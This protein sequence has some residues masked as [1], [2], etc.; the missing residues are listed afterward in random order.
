MPGRFLATLLT[1][2]ASLPAQDDK[3]APDASAQDAG[4]QVTAFLS[5]YCVRCHG[6]DRQKGELRLDTLSR[7]FEDLPTAEQWRAVFYRVRFDEMPP[8][9][10]KKQPKGDA[11]RALLE[12]IDRGLQAQGRGIHLAEKMRLPQYGNYVDH[13]MLFSGEVKELPYTEARLWRQRP[14]IYAQLWARHYGRQHRYSVKI[15]GAFRNGDLHQIQHGP[16]RGKPITARYFADERYANPFYEYVHHASGITDYADIAADQSSLEALLT[17]AEKMAEILT[18]GQPVAITTE[19]KT[20][21][22]RH[23]NNHGMFVG[24]EVSTSTELRGRIPRVFRAVMEHRAAVPR[25]VFANALQLGFQLF[26]RRVPSVEEV[27]HYFEDLFLKNASLGHTMALQ[28][29]LVAIAISPEFVYRMEM[30]L[31]DVDEH[32]RRL[33]SPLELVFALQYSLTDASPFG[34]DAFEADDVFQKQVEPLIQR[35]LTKDHRVAYPGHGWL[36]QQMQKGKLQTRA[37]VEAAVRHLLAAKPRNLTPNHNRDIQSVSNPRILQFFREFFGYH[38]AED[39]FKE[40]DNFKQREGFQ[41]FG[42]HTATRL[43]YDTDAL[44]LHVLREDRDVLYELL[45]TNKVFVSYWSGKHDK[46]QIRRAGGE[47]KYRLAH[48][49]QSYNLDPMTFD[50]QRGAPIEVPLDQRCGV[51]TQPSW[52]VAHSGNFD[53]DPVRRGKW[54][55]EKLLAGYV[56]DVPITVQAVIPDSETMTLRQRFEVVHDSECWQCH[57]KM[58]PLGMPFEAFNHVG[59][60]RDLER[61]KPVDTRGSVDYTDGYGLDGNAGDGNAGEGGLDGGVANVRE[62]MERLARSPLVRQSF[63]RHVFRFWMGRNE[64]LRDSQTLLA[65]DKAYVESGGSFRELLVSLLTSDS[66]LYRK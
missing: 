26:L 1:T 28:A 9:T 22:S 21:D 60:F 31:G 12:W 19:V 30:G 47:Q 14:G 8:R 39:V 59:R 42:N 29:V 13:K 23:G 63:I 4:K 10:T 40:V 44:V 5:N 48:D 33:L 66:F 11:R 37:D 16:H 3:P 18:V 64:A 65:M 35:A 50:H 52:L 27:E 49:T 55:R 51:L 53:N 62:M 41:Q 2:V 36:A 61:G 6:P 45:T 17:N 15:G 57:K 7:E 24:G 56:M 20:K 38:K 32:G 43:M 25:A 34:V 46:K 54:I 58:N